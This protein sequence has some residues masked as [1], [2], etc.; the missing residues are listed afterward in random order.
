MKLLLDTHTLLWYASG[1]SQLSTKAAALLGDPTNELFLSIATAWEL[2]IKT[3]LGKLALSVPS[4]EFVKQAAAA[5]G[6]TVLPI[7]IEDCALYEKLPFPLKDHRDPF[8]RLL[9]VQAQ[10]LG[11]SILGADTLFNAYQVTRVW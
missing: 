7:T 2:A 10:R 4:D 6:L 3:K 11:L 8:D 9:M 1:D 5:Y